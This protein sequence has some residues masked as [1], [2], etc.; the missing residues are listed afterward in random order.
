MWKAVEGAA[1]RQECPLNGCTS[2]SA[3]GAYFS[4]FGRL[5]RRPFNGYS[6]FASALAAG[7]CWEPETTSSPSHSCLQIGM[8]PATQP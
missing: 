1:A 5:H 3:V 6:T 2:M 4:I 8:G 7:R